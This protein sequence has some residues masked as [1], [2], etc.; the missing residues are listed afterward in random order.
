MHAL[1]HCPFITLSSR[2]HCPRARM[3]GTARWVSTTS[4][5][6]ISICRVCFPSQYP[7]TL[8]QSGVGPSSLLPSNPPTCPFKA[9]RILNRPSASTCPSVN[10]FAS[11]CMQPFYPCQ[12]NPQPNKPLLTHAYTPFVCRVGYLPLASTFSLP[13]HSAL[14]CPPRIR[15]LRR[16]LCCVPLTCVQLHMFLFAYVIGC[17][18]VA[19]QCLVTALKEILRATAH[20]LPPTPFL[21]V[22]L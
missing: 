2:D 16:I 14:I 4:A 17:E 10:H 7:A 1:L 12:P 21:A 8:N 22:V 20:L 3:H 9:F 13:T 19:G 6:F 15:H 5:F 18:S 11:T